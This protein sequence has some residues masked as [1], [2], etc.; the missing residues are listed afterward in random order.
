[1]PFLEDARHS[2]LVLV[3]CSKKMVRSLIDWHSSTPP[4]LL[5]SLG[6]LLESRHPQP[7]IRGSVVDEVE[8][9][10]GRP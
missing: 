6:D 3:W 1:M 7:V 9:P 2:S 4:T 10:V 5:V 8:K